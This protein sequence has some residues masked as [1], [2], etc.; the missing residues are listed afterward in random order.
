[1]RFYWDERFHPVTLDD[2]FDM[3]EGPFAALPPAAQGAWRVGVQ[4]REGSAAVV[5]AFDPPVVHV[6]DGTATM[7]TPQGPVG[8][9][10]CGC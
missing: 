7:Q 2:M 9:G 3:V 4:V 1:M 6:S 10:A 5:R 8:E